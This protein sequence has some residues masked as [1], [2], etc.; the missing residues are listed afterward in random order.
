[1]LPGGL[2]PRYTRGMTRTLLPLLGVA[3]AAAAARPAD[4]PKAAPVDTAFLKRYAETR[5]FML[6]RPAK[7]KVTPDGHACTPPTRRWP[8]GSGRGR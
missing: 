5:G 8:S 2:R 1:V 6:G 3:A 4:P 7:P